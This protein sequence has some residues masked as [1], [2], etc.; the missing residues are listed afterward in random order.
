MAKGISPS[1]INPMIVEC[2]SR[3]PTDTISLV[4][5][6]LAFVASAMDVEDEV[7]QELFC[8]CGAAQGLRIILMTCRSALEYHCDKEGGAS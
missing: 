2:G 4:N 8:S 7:A 3:P 5:D 6:V 1:V